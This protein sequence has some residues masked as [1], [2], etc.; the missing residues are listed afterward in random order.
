[1]GTPSQKRLAAKVTQQAPRC[2]INQSSSFRQQ[3]MQNNQSM[4][5]SKI[6]AIDPETAAAVGCALPLEEHWED[7]R[8]RGLVEKH[9][10]KSPAH[11]CAKNI[12]ANP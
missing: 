6:P 8:W 2:E 4:A 3:F 12:P 1:M 11:P 10:L 7:D 9:L 5:I